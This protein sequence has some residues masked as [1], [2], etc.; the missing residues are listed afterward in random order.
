MRSAV[1]ERST[2]LSTLSLGA[3]CAALTGAAFDATPATARDRSGPAARDYS[4]H[5]IA[6]IPSLCALRDM[7]RV[8]PLFIEHGDE[9][10]LMRG[11]HDFRIDCNVPYA[12]DVARIGRI[13]HGA[14]VIPLSADDHVDYEAKLEVPGVGETVVSTCNDAELRGER[15]CAGLAGPEDT[16]QFKPSARARMTLSQRPRPATP[17]EPADLPAFAGEMDLMNTVV[18][19][20]SVVTTSAQLDVDSR[21]TAPSH[22]ALTLSA[23]F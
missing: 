8:I 23:R 19:T 2:I 7:S 3:V 22:F 21:D 20:G 13:R 11:L 12:I 15:G 17:V 5:M 4:I 14:R 1:F 10:H 18:T 9:D 6:K 16:R